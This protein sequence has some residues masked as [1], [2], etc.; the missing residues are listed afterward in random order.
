MKKLLIFIIFLIGCSQ[1]NN[2]PCGSVKRGDYC[3]ND[4]FYIDRRPECENI[5]K[6]SKYKP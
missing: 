1:E 5:H 2:C 6:P 3:D 4:Y